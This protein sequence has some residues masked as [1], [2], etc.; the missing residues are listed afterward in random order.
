MSAIDVAIGLGAVVLLI[1]LHAFFVFA[2]F[3]LI[4]V[5][6][7]RVEQ[8]AEEGDK[9]AQKAL[10]ALKTL[11]FQLSGAQLGITV[12]SLIVGFL[13]EPTIGVALEP[14]LERL[15]FLPERSTLAVSV[16]LALVIATAVE[17]VMA[18]LIPKNYAIA[19]PLETSLAL[20]GP[21]R[22]FN[23]LFKPLILFLNSAANLTVR[24]FRIEP[25][26]ELAG[27]RTLDEL[28]RLIKTST[29]QKEEAALLTRSISFGDK[30]AADALIP[31]TSLLALESEATLHDLAVLALES[32]HSRFPVYARDLDD[33]VGI[34]HVKDSY[35]IPPDERPA[36]SVAQIMQDVMVVPESKD[37]DALLLEM[38]RE[39][40]QIAVVLDEYGGTAGIITLEDLL[41]E[42]VGE[43][44]DEYDL[45]RPVPAMTP[46]PE[47]VYV[48]S[49]MLHPDELREKTGFSMPDGD[50][51]TLAGFL[52]KRFD[53]IPEAGDHTGYDGWEF[54]VVEMDR[55]RIAK[56]L[57]VAPT[58]REPDDEATA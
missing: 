26:E 52:L 47:G 15:P 30:T 34:A 50:Y 42:I 16:V 19:K 33:I 38:R 17:M 20:A 25:R 40:R 32:G 14:L 28:D 57:A 6:R 2:E 24:L 51:E 49:G 21:M 58:N 3:G 44:E 29:L 31:R 37:L 41:E 48:L 7:T 43:I 46:S 45:D 4:A 11:S 35:R 54:K 8:L 23:G 18:E 1:A 56:V 22:F 12:T 5:E 39:R 27:V 10:A 9:R 13:A 53:R 55:K 36:V